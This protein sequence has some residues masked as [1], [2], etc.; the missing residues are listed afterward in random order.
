MK[1]ESNCLPKREKKCDS[2]LNA[3]CQEFYKESKKKFDSDPDFKERAQKAVVCL[4]VIFF[5]FNFCSLWTEV[6]ISQIMQNLR[7]LLKF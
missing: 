5:F 2:N 6:K 3:T 4:Q 1:C 7:S